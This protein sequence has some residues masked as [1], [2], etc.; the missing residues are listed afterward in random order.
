M[1]YKVQLVADDNGVA[2]AKRYIDANSFEYQMNMRNYMK[3]DDV[4][5][6][7]VKELRQN[8]EHGSTLEVMFNTA[9]TDLKYITAGNLAIY[10]ENQQCHVEQFAKLM[11]YDL[12]Q[13]FYLAENA[14]FS[15]RKSQ[16]NIPAGCYT[17][18]EALAKFVD[19]TGPL[20]KKNVKE[21][22]SK[23][24]D[25]AQKD[26]LLGMC[27]MGAAGKAFDEKLVSK[28][29]GL[30]DLVQMYPSMKIPFNTLIQKCETI[31]PRY[32]TIAS[33]TLVNPNKIRIAISLSK[34]D[35]PY[36]KGRL[37]LVSAYCKRMEV[38]K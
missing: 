23:C 2:E 5:I 19:L 35:S 7:S 31:M 9:G 26:E 34:F 37:G 36:E 20:K 38:D 21:F 4:S 16:L 14:D 13:R 25:A 32:Y 22:A 15:G 10:A 24:E 6:E 33:S 30:L 3:S 12:T 27:A 18:Q 11:G 8:L 29:V 17:V 1:A 28:N